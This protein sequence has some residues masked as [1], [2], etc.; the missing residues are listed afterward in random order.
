[1]SPSASQVDIVSLQAVAETSRWTTGK[2]AAIHRLAEH[3]AEHVRA[4]L[5]RM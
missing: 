5:P 3:T 4:R 2:I 1:M